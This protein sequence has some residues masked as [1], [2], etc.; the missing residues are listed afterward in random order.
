MADLYGLIGERLLHSFSPA[1][2]NIILNELS[3]TGTYDLLEIKEDNLKSLL[4]DLKQRCAI[5]VNVTIPYKTSVMLYLDNISPEASKIGAVNTIAFRDG[6]LTGYNTD[7]F[8]FGA[9]LINYNIDVKNKD[10]IVL[11][12]GGSSKA[13]VSYLIDNQISNITYVSR[14][15]KESSDNSWNLKTIS[16]G[17]LDFIKSSDIIINCTPVG[18]YPDIN[19][20]PVSTNILSKFDTAIDLIYNP[21]KTLFL[22]YAE[23]L[24]LNVINGL[25][26]LT[27]QAIASQEIWHNIK[28]NESKSKSIFRRVR[29][30]IY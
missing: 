22:K 14:N 12:T 2:Q 24:K 3:L 26:M 6:Q 29:E 11:G 28:I 10:A 17:D 18:M 20:F 21:E 4:D 1:I 19:K 25:Y 30:I 9:T 8:G 15:P 16:Y 13:V 27:A 7:Y 23:E 5:G